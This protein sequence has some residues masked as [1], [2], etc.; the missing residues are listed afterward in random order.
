[1]GSYRCEPIR[2]YYT[3]STTSTERSYSRY[4]PVPQNPSRYP[5]N[6]AAAYTPPENRTPVYEPPFVSSRA[7][8]VQTTPSTTSETTINSYPNY[9]LYPNPLRSNSSVVAGTLFPIG[10]FTTPSTTTST[11][12][13]P[14]P[15]LHFRPH[16]T[17]TDETLPYYSPKIKTTGET[18]PYYS[19]KPTTNSYTTV[20]FVLPERPTPLNPYYDIIN[21]QFRKCLPGYRINFRGQCEGISCCSS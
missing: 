4:S 12:T 11:T 7:Y 6:N 18:L 1:M 13:T 15:T 21:G 5:D 16:S 9:N 8:T 10:R 2:Q 14:R 17:A 20:H 19:P 3:P